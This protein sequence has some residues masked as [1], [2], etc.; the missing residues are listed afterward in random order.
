MA[1]FYAGLAEDNFTTYDEDN[2][3][4]QYITAADL[5]PSLVDV[6]SFL[7]EKKYT[8]QQPL[9]MVKTPTF[10]K[11]LQGLALAVCRGNPILLQGVTGSGK[12]ALI[13]YIASLTGNYKGTKVPLMS[14]SNLSL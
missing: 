2:D 5:V 6:C 4:G 7:L 10:E 12:T 9:K 8:A 13:D 14:V 11:N 1:S 3:H